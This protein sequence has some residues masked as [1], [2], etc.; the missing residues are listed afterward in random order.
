MMM[1]NS[2][3]KNNQNRITENYWTLAQTGDEIIKKTI[4]NKGLQ[5]C[6]NF[7]LIGWFEPI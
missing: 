3:E 6:Y 4:I 1:K 7:S 5:F 2:S